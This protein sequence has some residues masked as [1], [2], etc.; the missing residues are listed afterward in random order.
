MATKKSTG[1]IQGHATHRRT[2]VDYMATL[3]E[4]VTLDDWK[5]VVTGAVTLAKSGDAQARN[6]LGQ[7]LVGRPESKAPTAISVVVNQLRGHDAVVDRLST[8]FIN[9]HEM[10][11]LYA[12]EPF[13]ALV[14]QQIK[15][16]LNAK[17]KPANDGPANES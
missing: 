11:S 15:D 17:I 9:R 14:T 2:E 8:P 12:P 6:W 10:P 3:L 7:Y 16:E 1:L 5:S 13:A 4:T